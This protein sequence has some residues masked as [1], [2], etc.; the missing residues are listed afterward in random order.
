MTTKQYEPAYLK[1]LKE[2]EGNSFWRVGGFGVMPITWIYVGLIAAGLI[3]VKI[4]CGGY[5]F[6]VAC[7]MT[8]ALT[9]IGFL[10]NASWCVR[11]CWELN[12]RAENEDETTRKEMK[13]AA[14][15][16]RD[17]ADICRNWTVVYLAIA[18]GILALTDL[19]LTR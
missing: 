6:A 3:A 15:V 11:K 10:L 2:V 17:S 1:W 4:L 5:W 19:L 12:D 14:S 18:V 7:G 16:S 13:A 9:G 8:S